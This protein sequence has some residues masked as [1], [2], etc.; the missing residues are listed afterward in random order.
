ML[1][2]VERESLV[3]DVCC[4][5][6]S[7]GELFA[8]A[9]MLNA[10]LYHL[11]QGRFPIRF[12]LALRNLLLQGQYDVLHVHTGVHSCW[13][14]LAARLAGVPAVSTFHN[15]QFPRESRWS[16]HLLVGGRV[17]Q[18]A[19]QSLRYTLR[20]SRLCTGVSEGVVDAVRKVSGLVDSACEV[21]HL[22][23]A[24]LA[25][26][27]A[28]KKKQIRGSLGVSP[29]EKMILHVGSLS[30]QKNHLGLLEIFKKVHQSL[31]ATKLVLVGEGVQRQSI[32]N[33]I[34]NLGLKDA[35]TLLGLRKDVSE[36]MQCGDLF[37][38]PS[39]REGLSLTLMEASAACLPI[40]ASGIPGNRE[41]T[42]NGITARLHDVLDHQAMVASVCEL[43]TH[44]KCAAECIRKSRNLYEEKFS[45]EASSCRWLQIYERAVAAS[46]GQSQSSVNRLYTRKAA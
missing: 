17:K 46:K 44:P 25:E 40:V 4:K 28:R 45:L 19:R 32:E 5:G 38:F 29:E 31:P 2:H 20:N 33:R 8:E 13:G 15:T 1:K 42:A 41:A 30:E 34:A 7:Q 10:E 43:L 16:S 14:V 23:V 6:P 3:L 39:V 24:D 12:V 11:R 27:S 9:L 18:Y 35:V 22:G 21:C 26:I 37:L 36:L